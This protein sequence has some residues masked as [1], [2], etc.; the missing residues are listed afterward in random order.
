MPRIK[1]RLPD[2]PGVTR[3]RIA[4][5]LV[6][7]AA[8]PGAFADSASPPRTVAPTHAAL[9]SERDQGA[10][11]KRIE[12]LSE[13]VISDAKVSG[14]AIAIVQDDTVLLERGFGVVD[15][16]RRD[17]VDADTAF[18]L[19]SLSKA[20][21]GTLTAMLV[22]DGALR[23]DT[24]IAD[25]LPAFKLR[26][27]HSAQVL[28]VKDILSHRVGLPHNTHDRLLEADEPYPL[29]AARLS[30]AAP[31]CDAGQCYSYQNIAFSLIGDMTFAATG[32]F[33]SHQVE[34]R[35]FHPLGMYGATFGREA[36]EASP[37][38]ARP[39]IRRD[40]RWIAV[41]PKENYYRIPP[42]A[43]VNASIRDMSIWLR[44]QLGEYP[45]V[46]SDDVLASV[47]APLVST[48]GEL[49]GS[50]WR[51][52]RLRDAH[53]ALGWRVYDYAGHTLVYHGGA[54]QGYRS[55]VAFLPE[56]GFGMVMLWNCESGVPS[57]LLPTAL[58]RYLGLPQHDWLELDKFK[59]RAGG[60]KKRG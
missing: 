41:R 49:T 30:E 39:H 48:P 31:I 2:A 44:A 8:A 47:Q 10:L 5:L 53:Y 37:S 50:P 27:M 46:L 9:L 35:I 33:Y 12:A 45:E 51:R 24:R 28:T 25:H 6:A 26:N 59:P 38:W 17:P 42:A 23:W 36:L 21:A 1:E 11:A 54:V 15:T 55:M 43:G 20:F 13:R 7:L 14:M 16:A 57:G 52:E 18:R 32:D 22:E 56:Y 60:R 58:D 19:A 4:A 34:K 29:L 3:L 40:G